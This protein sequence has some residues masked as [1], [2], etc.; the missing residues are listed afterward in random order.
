MTE[1]ALLQD[2]RLKLSRGDVRL[3]R[4]NQGRFQD[5]TG[6]WIQFGVGNPGG[7]DL[8]GFRSVTISQ[9]HVGRTFAIFCAIE[10]K[11]SKGVVTA[12]Q[13]NFLSTVRRSGGIAGVARSVADAESLLVI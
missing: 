10:C 9:Q 6:R 2:I 1:T 11:S 3:F 8:I 13:E 7:S 5:I 4:N 12:E